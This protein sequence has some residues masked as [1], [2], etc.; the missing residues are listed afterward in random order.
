M[1]LTLSFD[2]LEDRRALLGQFASVQRVLDAPQSDG[3]DAAREQA[4]RMLLRLARG[5]SREVLQMI[6]ED[7]IPGLH[8]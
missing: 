5:V 2:R 7:P 4:F 6:N 8:G 3:N 1:K